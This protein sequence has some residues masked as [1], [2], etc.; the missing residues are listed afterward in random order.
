MNAAKQVYIFLLF[1]FSL[2]VYAQSKDGGGY[3]EV[4]ANGSWYRYN[5]GKVAGENNYSTVTAFGGGLAYRFLSNTSFEVAY[6]ET[7]TVDKFTQ[8]IPDLAQILRIKKTTRVQIMSA[9]LILD[10]ADRRSTFRPFLKAGGGYMIRHTQYAGTGVDRIT[11]TES[12]LN[13]KDPEKSESATA[14][15]GMGLKIFI[16]ESLALETSGTGYASDLDKDVIYI[17]Y[18]VSGGVRYIF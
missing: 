6:Q 3:F 4:F 11:N 1:L 7:K 5:Y 15:I 12:Q 9:S 13:I 18:S 10:L 2:N 8:D 14:Q 17:H 16:A